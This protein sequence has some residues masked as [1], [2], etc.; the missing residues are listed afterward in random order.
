MKKVL[1][2]YDYELYFNDS[3]YDEDEVLI[4][5][6]EMIFNA[7]MNN[8]TRCT[9]F[10]DTECILKYREIGSFNFV[11]KVEIQLLKFIKNGFD[12]QLHLHPLWKDARYDKGKWNF[13][14]NKY[15]IKSFSIQEIEEMIIR[16]KKYLED[17]LKQEDNRYICCVFRAGGFCFP[18]DRCFC[19]MLK[20]NGILIDS[21]IAPDTYLNSKYQS[22]DWTGK[23]KIIKS[24]NVI[25]IPLLTSKKLECHYLLNHKKMR[26]N[27]CLRGKGS[28]VIFLDR[29]VKRF[30]ISL[31]E[32]TLITLDTH[33][34][35]F[36][37]RCIDKSNNNILSIVGH[38]KLENEEIIDNTVRL[39]N[40]TNYKYKFLIFTE[41]IGEKNV[42]KS[43]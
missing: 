11:N 17:L 32:S 35:E 19:D 16:G 1:L 8:N 3:F 5:P 26:L 22:Y 9:F 15:S 18:N 24:H 29:A 6:A 34:Y 13:N 20:R 41:I 40:T 10:V 4:K 30:F 2:S 39:I 23:N 14:Y 43:N 31:R 28:P 12:V 25:E 21:S 37:E 27:Y 38:P 42:E 33:K 7:Y 36:I